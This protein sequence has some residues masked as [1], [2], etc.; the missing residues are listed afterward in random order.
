VRDQGL[1]FVRIPVIRRSI[2]EE[3]FLNTNAASGIDNS[4]LIGDYTI[5]ILVLIGCTMLVFLI[6]D[7]FID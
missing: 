2:V 5:I 7:V 4:C 3:E 6:P 1:G